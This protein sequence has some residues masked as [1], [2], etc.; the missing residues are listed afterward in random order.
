MDIRVSL[1]RKKKLKKKKGNT[2]EDF[3]LV[4]GHVR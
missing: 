2:F 4:F 1:R 3:C